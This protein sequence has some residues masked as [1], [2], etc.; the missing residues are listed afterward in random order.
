MH[1]IAVEICQKWLYEDLIY[2]LE[3]KEV[4]FELI[5]ISEL[6]LE[7]I[8][9]INPELTNKKF[10]KLKSKICSHYFVSILSSNLIQTT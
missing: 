8:N 3:S 5:E 6:V 1:L 4:T 7:K 10:F 2:F 9:L